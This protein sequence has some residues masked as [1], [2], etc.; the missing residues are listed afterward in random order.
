[1]RENEENQNA[2]MW[3]AHVDDNS[4]MDQNCNF[5]LPQGPLVL[6]FQNK[7]KSTDRWQP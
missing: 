2:L 3:G 5:C 6:K 4:F 1:M 7:T